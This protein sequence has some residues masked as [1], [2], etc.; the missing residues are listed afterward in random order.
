M[1]TLDADDLTCKRRNEALR[2]ATVVRP[3]ERPAARADGARL[4]ARS[5][6]GKRC[7]W[8]QVVFG[9]R[10]EGPPGASHEPSVGMTRLRSN[11]RYHV[12]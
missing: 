7:G 10:R 2:V 1:V 3:D 9:G 6:S 8:P 5:G 4:A 11:P 12:P